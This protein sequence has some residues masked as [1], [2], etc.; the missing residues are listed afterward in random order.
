MEKIRDL[1]SVY[2]CPLTQKNETVLQRI[3]ADLTHHAKPVSMTLDVQGR[4]LDVAK[5]CGKSVFF[6]FSELCE[7]PLGA[8][9]YLA[10]CQ[11]FHTLCVSGIPLLSPEK[12]N[13]ARRFIMLIDSLYDNRVKLI[14]TAAGKPQDIYPEG[15]GA[16]AF[17]RT[18]SRLMEMQSAQ[19]LANRK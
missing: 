11:K 6:T 18:I 10:L 4:K 7:K 8:A 19:Y 2:L 15:D 3:F 1:K 9:D 13:E 16:F 12:R 14:C 5:A 17:G